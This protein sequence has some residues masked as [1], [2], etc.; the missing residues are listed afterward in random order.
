M[1][2]ISKG[3]D[4]KARLQLLRMHRLLVFH[5]AFSDYL[6]GKVLG[7]YVAERARKMVEV[8]LPKLR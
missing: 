8:G 3:V 1:N 4:G 6:A 5:Q 2:V 7:T